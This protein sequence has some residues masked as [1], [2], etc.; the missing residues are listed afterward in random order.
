MSESIPP[1]SPQLISELEKDVGVSEGFFSQIIHED[2]WSLIIKLHGLI[3]AGLTQILSTYFGDPRLEQLFSRM[4]ISGRNGKLSFIQALDLL[5]ERN[6][7]FIRELSEIRNQIVHRITNVNFSIED[8]FK[9][10][11]R[12]KLLNFVDTCGDGVIPEDWADFSQNRSY[13]EKQ[14]DS[15]LK[16]PRELFWWSSVFVLGNIS[17]SKG[18]HRAS[19]EIADIERQAGK[20]LLKRDKLVQST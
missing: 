11:D 7:K 16:K 13:E 14:A 6:I 10:L 20:L 18:F 19:R 1:Y 3:E 15:F 2:D 17:K 4:N 12:Q 9:S 5:P 8:Y